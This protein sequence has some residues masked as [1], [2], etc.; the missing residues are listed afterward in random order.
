ML[1]GHLVSGAQIYTLPVKLI[2]L[3]IG[4]ASDYEIYGMFYETGA[5]LTI[6]QRAPS[7]S[8][9]DGHFDVDWTLGRPIYGFG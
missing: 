4:H 2:G 8:L 7:D 6:S 5:A 3:S 9:E 1:S